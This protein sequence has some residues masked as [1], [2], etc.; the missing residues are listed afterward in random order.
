MNTR[1][2]ERLPCRKINNY[3]CYNANHPADNNNNNNN[4][5]LLLHKRFDRPLWDGQNWGSL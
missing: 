5:M 4:K 1:S 3:G 2:Q